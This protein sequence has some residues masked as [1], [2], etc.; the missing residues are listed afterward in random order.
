MTETGFASALDTAHAIAS[1]ASLAVDVVEQA[2]DGIAQRDPRINAFTAVTAG[3]AL[4]QARTI[5]AQRRAGLPLPPLAGVPFA[6]KNLFDIEGLPTLAGSRVQREAAP[7]TA[8]AALVEW[9]T[10]AGAVLVG[11]LNMDEFAFGFSTENSHVG[12]TRNP[13]DTERMAG[14]SSGG[15]AAAVAAGMVP[16]T[17]GSDTNGSIRVPASLCGVYGLKPTYGRLSRRGTYPFVASLDHVGPFARTV[18]DLAACYDAMQGPDPMDPACAQRPVQV[19]A[20]TLAQG[21][22]G[23][24]VARLG[25]YFDENAGPQALAAVDACCAAL[26]VRRTVELPMA[27]LGRAAAFLITSSEGG[28][29]HLAALREQYAQ[30]EPMSRDRFIA[31]ALM[32]AAWGLA[33]QRL[34]AKYRAAANALFADVDV[35]IA[36]ATP[37]AAPTIGADWVE[38]NGQRVLSRAHLGVLTQPISCIGLPV[39]AVPVHTDAPL[40]IG[41][42]V[43]AAPWREAD[44]LRVAA[45]LARHGVARV[46]EPPFA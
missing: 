38:L 36:A 20:P 45:A 26:D 42:Q 5:D 15:S 46:T 16:L 8:D 44:A 33:A 1:G 28:A 27:G 23:L 12:P 37:Y 31:G 7:A 9:L 14:G 34:R 2:L 24:R 17:L 10:R 39:V 43:I 21:P 11:A 40:P 30:Y 22:A 35:L 6:V 41:V 13:H 19:T 3:R 29:L 18:E 32:P 25:G 4:D